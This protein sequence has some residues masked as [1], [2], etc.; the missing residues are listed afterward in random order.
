MK[1]GPGFARRV[2]VFGRVCGTGGIFRVGHLVV[3]CTGVVI[4][5][6]SVDSFS[7]NSR[8]EITVK[9]RTIT[10]P[11]E[12]APWISADSGDLKGL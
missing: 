12:A 6:S 4:H 7:S 2:V 3:F 10:N 8:T 11:D 1:L 5:P 9:R